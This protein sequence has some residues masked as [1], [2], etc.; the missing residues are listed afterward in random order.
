LNRVSIEH[1][2]QRVVVVAHGGVV[3]ASFVALG[4]VPIGKAF[5]FTAETK[6][7]SITEWSHTEGG[8]RLV[9]FNDAGHLSQLGV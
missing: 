5:A 9:R 4:D 1:P 2:G 3:D 7:A 8:W 6:N